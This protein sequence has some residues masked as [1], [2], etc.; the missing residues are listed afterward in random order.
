VAHISSIH[1]AWTCQVMATRNRT[2]YITNLYHSEASW[3]WPTTDLILVFWVSPTKIAQH[4]HQRALKP[5]RRMLMNITAFC[6]DW[7]VSQLLHCWEIILPRLAKTVHTPQQHYNTK[8]HIK[9]SPV[10]TH[11]TIKVYNKHRSTQTMAV[12]WVST[13]CS[14]IVQRF[15]GDLL[16]PPSR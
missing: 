9:A 7:Q 14:D 1:N 15:Q 6:G 4:L 12:F 16:P 3:T 13:P 10:S 8:Q 5:K 11:H 2:S